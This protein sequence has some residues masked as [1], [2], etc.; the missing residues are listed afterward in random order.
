MTD[1]P[2]SRQYET[3]IR[4]NA[5]NAEVRFYRAK[6]RSILAARLP[7]PP[8]VPCDYC[9]AQPGDFCEYD[10]GSPFPVLDGAYVEGDP[11]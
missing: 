7:G 5:D 8:G 3:A 2:L 10:C 11:L 9:Q 4:R 1:S 6:L